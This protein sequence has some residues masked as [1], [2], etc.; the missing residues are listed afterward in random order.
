MGT[1]TSNYGF[2][3]PDESDSMADVEVNI[4]DNFEIIASKGEPTVIAAGAALPQVGDYELFD[5]VFRDDARTD[6]TWPSLYILVCK[7]ENWGWHWR[8]IQQ[9]TSP[10]VNVP[11][12]AIQDA[13]F[14]LG[15]TA[16][17]Q[18]ALDSRGWCHWR[19]RISRTSV[20][21]PSATS[22]SVFKTL[23][24]GL[25]PCFEAM[26]TTALSP[27][28]S[29]AG[30]AGNTGGRFFMNEDGTSSVRCFNSTATQHIWFDGLHYNTAYHWYYSA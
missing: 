17:V 30:K 27:I 1:T 12:T 10:W 20:G 26:Y 21:I 8:P 28:Q 18:I 3:M 25:R 14:Q 15:T 19:G 5:M 29:A 2:F 24:L 16:P 9:I 11:A 7:D 13:N 22:F 23:P 6:T 4:T